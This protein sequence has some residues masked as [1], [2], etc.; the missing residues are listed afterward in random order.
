MRY[1]WLSFPLGLDDP[2]PPAIPAPTL[3]PFLTIESDGANVQILRLASHTGT[4]VDSPLHV[5][6]NGISITEF[7][8]EEFIYVKPVVMDLRLADAQVVTSDHLKPFASLLADADI[9]LFRF[10]VGEIRRSDPRRFSLKSPG[11]GVEA[12]GWLKAKCPNL[13][14]LGMDVPSLACID[15]L[16]ETMTAHNVLLGGEGSRFLVIEDMNLEHDLT[17]LKEVRISPWL[18]SGMDSGPC[19]VVCVLD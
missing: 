7:A 19:S 16:D 12:A 8:P 2:R 10:G 9:A 17:G 3:E 5:V 6:E 11:F 1:V 15:R 13:R 14:A 18:V 4:H